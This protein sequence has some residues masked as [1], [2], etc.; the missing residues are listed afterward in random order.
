[1]IM[2]FKTFRVFLDF[3]CDLHH[4]FYKQ[5]VVRLRLYNMYIRHLNCFN[6]MNREKYACKQKQ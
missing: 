5:Y 1:M 6:V 4:Y 2:T 3:R